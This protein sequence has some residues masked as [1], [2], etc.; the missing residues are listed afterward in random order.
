[1]VPPSHQALPA[2]GSL[3]QTGLHQGATTHAGRPAIRR[4]VDDHLD[5]QVIEQPSVARTIVTL[6][7][8]VA[9][10]FDIEPPDSRLP[11]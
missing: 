11:R 2:A 9:E 6:G 1:M 3:V 5:L 7:E 10:A 8:I 4:H